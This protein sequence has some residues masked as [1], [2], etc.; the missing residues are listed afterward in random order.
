MVNPDLTNEDTLLLK[1]TT[2][3]DEIKELSYETEKPDHENVFKSPKVDGDYCK[4]KHRS[5]INKR[6][7]LSSSEF[8]VGS[9]STTTTSTLSLLNPSVGIIGTSSSALLTSTAIFIEN[10]Y[11]S[12]LKIRYGKLRRS[13]NVII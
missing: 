11:V 1:K 12:N 10:E 4:K 3:D 7:I 13:I 9:G 5:F 8:I 2:W 6:K